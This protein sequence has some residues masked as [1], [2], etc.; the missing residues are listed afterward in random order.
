VTSKGVSIIFYLNKL[1]NSNTYQLAKSGSL[2]KVTIEDKVCEIYSPWVATLLHLGIIPEPDEVIK[3][4]ADEIKSI[5]KGYKKGYLE[6]QKYFINEYKNNPFQSK[7][8]IVKDVLKLEKEVKGE[9]A[10][11]ETILSF[12]VFY[13]YGRSSGIY[14]E[15]N[16]F[17]DLNQSLFHMKHEEIL[18]QTK[19][20]QHLFKEKIRFETTISLLEKN[21]F[22][23]KQNEVLTFIGDKKHLSLS[24]KKLIS[25]LG[26]VLNNELHL[27][28]DN[29]SNSDISKA[30]TRAFEVN[31]SKQNYSAAIKDFLFG[32]EKA[33][34]YL[35]SYFFLR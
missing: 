30:L 28:K 24:Q 14:M 6:G 8:T 29:L 21:G 31:I 3:T 15:L 13:E 35:E 23:E 10:K 17:K 9:I 20:L 1:Y 25:A 19:V 27:L 7:E 22:V 12:D 11:R 34:E 18:S 33:K 4:L 2:T 26:F 16:K 5:K 32:S